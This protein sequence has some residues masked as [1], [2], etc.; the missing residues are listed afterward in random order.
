[1][2]LDGPNGLGN[3]VYKLDTPAVAAIRNGRAD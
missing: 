1:M 2:R 3:E